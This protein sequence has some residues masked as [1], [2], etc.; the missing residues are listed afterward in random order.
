M[1]KKLISSGILF[2]TMGLVSYAEK[3]EETYVVKKNDNLYEI[4]K[5]LNVDIEHL[6]KENNIKN[7]NLIYPNKKL[8][9]FKENELEPKS[10]IGEYKV[11]RND[12]L[13][14]ISKKLNV[15]LNSILELNNIKN[16]NLIYSGQI[17]KVPLTTKI[18][19]V[20]MT[21]NSYL[22]IYYKGE[23]V[24]Y[25]TSDEKSIVNINGDKISLDE[26]L[27]L[28]LYKEGGDVIEKEVIQNE[29]EINF[30][31]FID[32]N[33]NNKLD[34]EDELI[35]DGSYKIDN[36]EINISE[37]GK[38][39]I[40]NLKFE[41]SYDI[42]LN[43]PERNIVNKKVTVTVDNEEMYLPI[44]NENISVNGK[45][46]LESK[47]IFK[48]NKYKSEE[49]LI[50]I[51]NSSGAELLLLPVDTEGNFYIEELPKGEYYYEIEVITP[52]Q[53]KT[54]EKNKKLDIVEGRVN[55]HLK[56]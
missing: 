11:K 6:I 2:S 51:K 41:K 22:E 9:Y 19:K 46:T 29:K 55:I 44:K 14:K 33:D 3:I 17:I 21:P 1:K 28:K 15:N 20:E 30:I 27:K 53:I 54:L 47:S 23:V 36:E 16:P 10:K 4:S 37:F 35:T 32:K 5:K 52:T 31:S 49:L 38:T 50:R 24:G 43:S 40:P 18:L 42:I 26:N 56:Y 45:I 12:T 48:R 8:R 39:L 25:K 13:Y 7:P 34:P